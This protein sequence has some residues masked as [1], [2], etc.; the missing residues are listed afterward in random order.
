MRRFAVALRLGVK[1]NECL[2]QC[3]EA[4]DGV[5]LCRKVITWSAASGGK[6]RRTRASRR[7]LQLVFATDAPT[8]FS[9]NRSRLDRTLPR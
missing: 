7:G 2:G 6:S 3:S 8:R 9:F 5:A 4:A 1:Q